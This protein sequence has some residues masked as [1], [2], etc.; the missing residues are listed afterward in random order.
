MQKMLNIGNKHANTICDTCLKL[1][2]E[3]Q[4]SVIYFHFDQ[5]SIMPTVSLVLTFNKYT[6]LGVLSFSIH[7]FY[8]SI[9]IYTQSK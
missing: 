6:A 9:Y 4:N 2:I 5:L 7:E 1:P 8:G 3:A